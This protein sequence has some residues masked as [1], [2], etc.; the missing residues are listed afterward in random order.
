[1]KK[2]GVPKKLKSKDKEPYQLEAKPLLEHLRDLRR[3]LFFC[4]GVILV[5]FLIIF[6]LL[7]KD[8]VLW[9]SQPI[10]DMNIDIIYIDISEAFTSQLKLSL[11][12]GAVVASPVVFI[13]IWLFIRPALYKEERV[14]FGFMTIL[15][16]LLFVT[17]VV[18]AY[19][20]VFR[21]A[22]NFFIVSGEN[23]ATPMVSLERYVSFLFS[24]LLPFG[25]MFETPIAVLVLTRI[26]IVTP[27][28]LGKA[29]KFI[30]F[31]IFVVAAILTPP[32]IISQIM[33]ALPL[34]VLFEISI[35]LS[36]LVRP[37]KKEE[38]I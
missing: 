21:L 18:F 31:A 20:M 19:F 37:R 27:K 32:D 13:A 35:L 30:I 29:R 9:I 4:L 22:V 11:I 14:V 3:L 36:R 16:L 25:V 2:N 34:L 24:F 17:G 33:L 5:A 12:A 8:L 23:I 1:M 26:G 7:S 6:A 28:L 10:V 38:E 15:A